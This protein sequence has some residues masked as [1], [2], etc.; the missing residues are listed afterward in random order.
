M[1]WIHN[2]QWK[3]SEKQTAR[4]Q[5]QILGIW[6][7]WSQTTKQ[8]MG[9]YASCHIQRHQNR[10]SRK[11]Q[12]QHES[13]STSKSASSL[14]VSLPLTTE[15]PDIVVVH[16]RCCIGHLAYCSLTKLLDDSVS[17]FIYFHLGFIIN[18]DY[19]TFSEFHKIQF[20]VNDSQTYHSRTISNQWWSIY[21]SEEGSYSIISIYLYTYIAYLMDSKHGL[22]HHL[23]PIKPSWQSVK[24]PR[25]TPNSSFDKSAHC[26]H[27]ANRRVYP[28]GFST[29]WHDFFCLTN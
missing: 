14:W 12:L 26:F 3:A 22:Q 1:L 10:L 7:S 28:L 9:M 15:Y 23:L 21:S 8:R 27:H 29:I 2:T 20:L 17:S 11:S 5:V 4:F 13:P 25:S 19:L 18:P 24:L 6:F 16:Y